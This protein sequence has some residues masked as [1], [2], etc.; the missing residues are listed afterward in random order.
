MSRKPFLIAFLWGP[1]NLSTYIRGGAMWSIFSF[2]PCLS[3]A[4]CLG[5]SAQGY[6]SASSIILVVLFFSTCQWFLRGGEKSETTHVAVLVTS[7][8]PWT[9]SK[10]PFIC[11]FISA[12]CHHCTQVVCNLIIKEFNLQSRQ[13]YEKLNASPWSLF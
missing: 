8:L 13:S 3:N 12:W 7:L 6:L 1:P 2:F 5:L 11:I 10:F 4:V 9:S